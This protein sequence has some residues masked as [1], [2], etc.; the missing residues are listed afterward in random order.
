MLHS[1]CISSQPSKS[2]G[3][4]LHTPI[5]RFTS[6]KD[7]PF[8]PNYLTIKTASPKPFQ[9]HYVDVKPKFAASQTILCLHG[10]PSWSYLYRGFVGPLV[11]KGYRVVLLDFNGFGKVRNCLGAKR[12]A[13][14]A[15]MPLVTRLRV[16]AQSYRLTPI[17][18]RHVILTL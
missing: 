1:S 5:A 6:L 17:Y 9:V 12:R 3:F 4:L 18:H 8:P 15:L 10:E 13:V 2:K 7:F 11:S 14:N 16:R